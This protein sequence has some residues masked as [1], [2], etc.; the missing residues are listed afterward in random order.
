MR[1]ARSTSDPD[2]MRIIQA[3]QLCTHFSAMSAETIATVNQRAAANYRVTRTFL[4]Q[5][6]R[7]GILKTRDTV[8]LTDILWS[9]F[10]G[11]V[12]LEESKARTTRKDHLKETLRAAFEILADGL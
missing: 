2:R 10:I 8:Q 5:A 3:L 12:Q 4:A 7:D 11:V 9:M 6:M 1:S